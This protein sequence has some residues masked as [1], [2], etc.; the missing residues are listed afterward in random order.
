MIKQ[1]WTIRD[2]HKLFTGLNFSIAIFSLG[3]TIL[4]IFTLPDKIDYGYSPSAGINIVESKY[5][6]LPLPIV[7]LLICIAVYLMIK[8]FSKSK[9]NNPDSIKATKNALNGSNFILMLLLFFIELDFINKAKQ[10]GGF[11]PIIILFLMIAFAIF[12][13]YQIIRRI[14]KKQKK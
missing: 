7:A 5:A 8:Y 9:Q 11:S 6:L 1:I 10:V 3:Y 4:N 14:P 13:I 12:V 2:I